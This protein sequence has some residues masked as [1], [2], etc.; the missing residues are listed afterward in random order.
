MTFAWHVTR[1]LLFRGLLR[2]DPASRMSL[3]AA[4]DIIGTLWKDM[5]SCS[6]PTAMQVRTEFY[7]FAVFAIILHLSL[8]T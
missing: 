1:V 3:A 4:S 2:A 7:I 8:A 5:Q 6:Y